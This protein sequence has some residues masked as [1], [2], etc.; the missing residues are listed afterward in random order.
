LDRGITFVK[1][2]AFLQNDKMY[3]KNLQDAVISCRRRLHHHSE[4]ERLN[5]KELSV[6][7]VPDTSRR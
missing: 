6:G 3:Q 1:I 2:K 7:T 4:Q 5:N